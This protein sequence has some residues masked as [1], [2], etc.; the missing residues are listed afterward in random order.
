MATTFHDHLILNR[1]LLSLFHHQDL[2]ALKQRLG[3]SEGVAED[4]QTYFFHALTGV[5]FFNHDTALTETDLRRYDLHIVQHWQQI[6]EQRNRDEGHEL[7]MKYFQYLSLLFSEIYLDW[8]FNRKAELQT[9][10]NQALDAYLQERHAEQLQKYRLN[11]LNK[12]AFWNATGSGKTLLMH[13]NILQY[14]HYF[15]AGSTQSP[16]KIIV[17]TPNDNLSRQH[18]AELKQS[19]LEAALFDKNTSGVGRQSA[20]GLH[21]TPL[22]EVIDIHKLADKDGD[23]TVSVEAFNGNNLVL[24]DEGHRGASGKVWLERRDALVKG[25]FAFEYSATLGQSAKDVKTVA[26]QEIELQKNKAK[27]LFG[28]KTLN[29]LDEEQLAQLQLTESDKQKARQTAVFEIYAKAVLFD[30]SYKFFYGDGYGKESLILNM[31]DEA[32]QQYD[33]QYFTACLLAFY[34]QLYLFEHG[35]ERLAEWNLEKPLMVF[36][37]NKVA[38]DDSDVLA[39]VRYLAFFLNEPLQIQRWLKDL[40]ADNAQILDN[41]GNNIFLQRFLPL[42]AWMGK[43]SDLY[44]DIL[45]RLFNAPSRQH[46]HLTHLK[47]SNG[48]LA[49]S[50]GSQ[51]KPFGVIN[52]GDAAGFLK[53]AA[54]D[55]SFDS[56]SDDFSDGLFADINHE[57]SKINLLIGSKKF[58]EG[59]SSWRVSTMGLLNMGKGEG[60]Q[61]IQLFGRGVRLKGRNFS[62]KRS[63]PEERPHGL[64]LDKLE[65]LNIFGVNAGYM[66]QFKK[67]LKEEGVTPSDEMLT[68]DFQVQPNLPARKLKTLRLKDGYKDNQ[69]QG[70]KRSQ[71]VWLYEIPE[72]WQGKIKPIRALLDCYPRVEALSS[73]GAQIRR[74]E[75]DQ[76]EIHTLNSHLFDWFDWDKIY[77]HLL[78]YKLKRTWNNLRL[79]KGRLKTFAEQ[80]DWYTLY[81]PQSEL[82][83]NSFADIEKQQALLMDLL[84]N[85]TDQFYNRLKSAYEAQFYESVWVDEKNGSMFDGYHFEIE[86]SDNGRAYESRLNELKEI[87]ESGRL[88]EALA[89]EAPNIEAICFAPHL[90]YPIMTLQNRDALPL[91]MK[92]LA[93]NENSEIR[94]VHDLQELHQNGRLPDLTGGKE[95]YLLRNAANKSKGLGFALAGNFYPDF[96]LW[97]VDQESDKQW[98]SFVDPKGL[99]HMSLEDPK[100][101]LAEEVKKL[102]KDMKLQDM[103]L[104]S[105]ILSVTPQAEVPAFTGISDKTLEDKHILFMDENKIYL[106]Q[107][108]EIILAE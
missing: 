10:L 75:Y 47:K 59:W 11:D 100:F 40:L 6:T 25:G 105:F 95:L 54:E 4:G 41:Q 102:E 67:Y 104:N 24:V 106:K 83:V 64:H 65:T 16:D 12:I 57:S 88:K 29:G 72:K 87:I 98:L 20:L 62:L 21:Q 63:L 107:M 56:S 2:P 23:K 48:E 38:D 86:P 49:L 58:T 7:Q 73:D 71:N 103:S 85:Y 45:Q 46:L 80:N 52:I 77:L 51:N 99:R 66:E 70:F 26:K 74:T 14:L 32:Y 31:K 76:R 28:K 97:L 3:N 96:L 36:V 79:D 78:D 84:V 101:G 108:F 69:K 68:V 92:P 13:I 93:M 5:L 1:W 35:K 18:V 55:E 22:I 90:Y 17:L 43:E 39:I 89:W 53:T 33:K 60:S 15:S 50:I 61:I 30:Y 27:M 42:S 34:Q 81:I 94:F 19:G 8:Y 9:A 91:T 44:A 82:A 37:G